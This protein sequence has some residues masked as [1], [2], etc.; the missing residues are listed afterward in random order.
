MKR[1]TTTLPESPALIAVDLGYSASQ[2]SCG[3]AFS[4]GDTAEH[5]FGDCIRVVSQHLTSEGPATLILE[6]VLSTFHNV[7]GNP[8]IRGEF[9]KGRGW[10]HGPGVSTYAAAV[11]FLQELDRIL[12]D[13]LRPIPLVE[14]FLSY[15][16]N[17]T[18]HRSDAER[19]VTEFETAERF[20]A[21]SGSE[22][23]IEKIDGV[24]EILRFNPPPGKK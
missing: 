11:R 15:K 5:T 14:G 21:A 17:K 12:P 10:Y 19:M 23:V 16:P 18:T 7:E 8:T 4:N 20:A 1:F 24:P 22:P 13:E 6:A 3:I 2:K 9:E